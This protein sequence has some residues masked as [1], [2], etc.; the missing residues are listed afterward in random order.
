MDEL[1]IE[2]FTAEE[3]EALES[4]ERKYAIIREETLLVA[5][6]NSSGLYVWGEGGIGKSW[7]VI[8]TLRKYGYTFR[9]KNTRLSVAGF[10]EELRDHPKGLFLLEDLPDIADTTASRNLLLAALWGQPD[11]ETG[12]MERLVPWT[13]SGDR[14][15][16]TK[17]YGGIICTANK[18]MA[19]I[20]EL[21]AIATRIEVIGLACTREE[22]LAVAKE[23]ALDGFRFNGGSLSPQECLDMWSFYKKELPEGRMADLRILVR[24]ARKRLGMEEMRR[25]GLPLTRTWQEMLLA[26]IHQG[27]PPEPVLTPGARKLNDE[28]VAVE[29]SRKYPDPRD[30]GQRDKEW[31]ER[32]GHHPL[33]YY[34]VLNRAG[35]RR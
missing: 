16:E 29:L 33:T 8:Q 5:L 25:K 27:P 34:K 15:F 20:P 19:D 17:F 12:Q 26:M 21:R 28:E 23:V 3:L 7:N 24:A 10:G 31:Q 9:H 22:I 11:P 1:R 13:V 14:K 35:K 32:T 30:R 2:E 18:P 6:G 4:L